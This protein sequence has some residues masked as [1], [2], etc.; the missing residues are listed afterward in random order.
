MISLIDSTSHR[1]CLV[2]TS[3][4]R[5]IQQELLAAEAAA[6]PTVLCNAATAIEVPAKRV[7]R[8]LQ[9][10]RIKQSAKPALL[11]TP[12]THSYVRP[13]SRA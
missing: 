7:K 11:L 8:S 12:C 1:Y 4:L 6:L 5:E 9:V 10:C 13:D 3:P 2:V